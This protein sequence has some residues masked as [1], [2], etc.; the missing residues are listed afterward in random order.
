MSGFPAVLAASTDSAYCVAGKGL[1][2]QGPVLWGAVYR[3]PFARGGGACVWA[4]HANAPGKLAQDPHVV[5][6]RTSDRAPARCFLERFFLY[7][8][9]IFTMEYQKNETAFFLIYAVNGYSTS[10]KGTGKGFDNPDYY[11]VKQGNIRTS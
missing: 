8:L 5:V 1:L 6:G 10:V 7:V 3:P 2:A 4:D 11:V 9:G